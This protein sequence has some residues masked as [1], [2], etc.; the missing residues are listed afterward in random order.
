[1]GLGSLNPFKAANKIGLGTD[2]LFGTDVSGKQK[3]DINSV[4]G[5]LGAQI[6]ASKASSKASLLKALQGIEAGFGGAHEALSMQGALG[7]KSILDRERVGLANNRQSLISRGLDSSTVATAMDRGTAADTNQSLNELNSML[8]QIG[9]NIDI[10][11]GQAMAS[12]YGDLASVDQNYAQIMAS[13]GL[14]KLGAVQNV[15][16]GKQ[17]GALGDILKI[18]VGAMSGGLG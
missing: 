5:P 15:Q 14:G 2:F 6:G 18:G 4:M 1:M 8:A 9:S 16:Y 13:L 12:A 10:S 11:K 17:G 3:K 7:T